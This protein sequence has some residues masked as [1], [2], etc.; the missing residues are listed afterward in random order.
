MHVTAYKTKKIL[1]HD[2][3]NAILNQ[4][5]PQLEEKSVVI[6]TS[7]IVSL[8][9]GR[10][11]RLSSSITK[12]ELIKR[13]ATY[14]I[15]RTVSKYGYPITINENMLVASAGIDESNAAN[16]YVLWPKNPQKTVNELWRYLRK[17]YGIKY[18]GVIISDSKVYPLRW[19]VVG[20]AIVHAG[21]EALN[22]YRGTPDLFG[23]PLHV[24]QANVRDG[25]A[26]AAVLV[27]GEGKEQTPLAV[28]TEVSFVKFQ[29]RTPS[30]PE[31]ANLHIEI[32]DDV[33]APLLDSPLW[34][35]GKGR[36]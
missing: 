28:I 35:K 8:C 15:D 27:M 4:Y 10:V 19:G 21:F 34:K 17:K 33:F 26:G 22:D 13:E 9:Q 16:H 32:A 11:V 24:T 31:L 1:P 25:L 7:K 14:Y 12:D 5:L 2:N 20:A 29:N 30:K 6:I 3:L 23:H 36:K 18:L